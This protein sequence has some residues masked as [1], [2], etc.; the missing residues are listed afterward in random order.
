[1]NNREK[2]KSLLQHYF[3]HVWE[4]A[5]LGWDG[6]NSSEIDELADCLIDAAKDE[7]KNEE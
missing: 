3:R 2:A 1:M 7:I 5:G 6:D 4:S